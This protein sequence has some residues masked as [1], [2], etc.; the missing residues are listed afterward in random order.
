MNPSRVRATASGCAVRKPS[1]NQ[2]GT[3]V[4]TTAA[5]PEARTMLARLCQNSGGGNCAAV[6]HRISLSTRAG[7][8]TAKACAMTP[9]SDRPATLAVAISSWSRSMARSVARSSTVNALSR[10]PDLPWPR[11]S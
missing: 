5:S 11:V 9:P 7:Y 3:I 1:V 10:E 8:F 6:A 4:S 2:R